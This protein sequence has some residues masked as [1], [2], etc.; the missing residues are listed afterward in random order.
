MKI[1]KVKNN[2]STAWRNDKDKYHR[3]DGPAVVVY[4]EDFHAE[5]WYKNGKL[6]RIDAPAVTDSFGNEDWYYEGKRHRIGGPAITRANKPTEW[7]VHGKLV[8]P[9]EG[10]LRPIRKRINTTALIVIAV[11]AIVIFC[12]LRN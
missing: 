1:E 9:L 3:L 4:G 6:H 8:E 12:I 7:Y 10:H 2:Q 5:Y 11:I